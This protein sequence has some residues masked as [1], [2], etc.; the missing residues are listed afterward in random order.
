MSDNKMRI[1]ITGS[2]GLLGSKISQSL[3]QNYDII[4]LDLQLIKAFPKERQIWSK[5]YARDSD[6][7]MTLYSS[8]AMDVANEINLELSNAQVVRFSRPDQIKSETYNAYLRGMYFINGSTEEDFKKGM[9]YLQEAVSLDPANPLAYS[10]LAIGY[11]MLG[12]GPDPDD[13]VWKRAKAA[14]EQAIKL[15]STIAEAHTVL[16]LIKFY[17]ELDWEGAE[18]AFL[19]ALKITF[20]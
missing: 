5:E 3:E 18:K 20:N 17:R 1:I 4:K 2:E 8:I 7:I 6:E 19:K 15:D 10:G 9:T 11:A 12:H 13:P 16:A 14:A